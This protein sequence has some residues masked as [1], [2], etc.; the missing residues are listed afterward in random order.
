[1][2]PKEDMTAMHCI[3]FF[4]YNLNVDILFTLLLP[5]GPQFLKNDLKNDPPTPATPEEEKRGSRPVSRVP[6]V[7]LDAEGPFEQPQAS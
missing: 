6:S 4:S 2:P 3:V 7:P 5:P 1:M